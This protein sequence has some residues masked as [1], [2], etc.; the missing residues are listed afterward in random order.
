M[1]NNGLTAIG[2]F[3]STTMALL[4]LAFIASF[5]GNGGKVCFE[6]AA[7]PISLASIL[8]FNQETFSLLMKKRGIDVAHPSMSPEAMSGALRAWVRLTRHRSKPSPK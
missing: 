3:D 7:C 6:I 5:P 8:Y 1:N 2:Y 4:A